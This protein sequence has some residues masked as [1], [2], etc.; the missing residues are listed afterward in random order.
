MKGNACMLENMPP[1]SY[2]SLSIAAALT[3]ITAR[4]CS[5]G[6]ARYAPPRGVGVIVDPEHGRIEAVVDDDV[7]LG[8]LLVVA[9]RLRD[10]VAGANAVALWKK[11]AQPVA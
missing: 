2:V 10:D 6:M 11:R 5:A 7:V 4:T 3:S 8:Q 1:T 9:R